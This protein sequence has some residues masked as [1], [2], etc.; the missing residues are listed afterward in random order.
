MTALRR[1]ELCGLER[2]SVESSC[3]AVIFSVLCDF[4]P[5]HFL[6]DYFPQ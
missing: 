5:I 6:P 3:V 1:F 2:A 4:F